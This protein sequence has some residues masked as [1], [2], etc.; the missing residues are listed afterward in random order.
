MNITKNKNVRSKVK[1][2]DIGENILGSET[3]FDT[4]ETYKAIRTNVMFAI[5]KKDAGRSI[6]VTSASP[7]EGKSTTSV[8]LAITFAQ[9]GL[10]TIIVDCDLRK[11]SVHRYLFLER[12]DGVSNVVC[13]FTQLE[14]AIKRNVRP[15]LDVL[16][17][18]QIPPNPSELLESEEFSKML[19]KLE[20]IYDYIIIDTPP[21]TIVT[22]ASVVMKQSSGVIVSVWQDVTTFDL[23]DIAVDA[24]NSSG[25]KILG[26]VVHGCEDKHKKY[27]YY[28]K[29]KYKYKY[30]YKYGYRYKYNDKYE[31]SSGGGT[32]SK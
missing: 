9:A 5:P 18:G 7:G 29:G 3:D 22:D 23:L 21:I 14:D 28:Q 15:C 20:E 26:A 12:K 2:T 1:V 25:T 31:D 8:N 32:T 6:V 19:R 11:P 30:G 10:K 4:V 24:I 13:G 16:T 17:A 27:G